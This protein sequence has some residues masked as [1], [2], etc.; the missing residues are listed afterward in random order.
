MYMHK[1]IIKTKWVSEV[2]ITPMHHDVSR[3]QP[4][5]KW[6]QL[7]QDR[8]SRIDFMTAEYVYPKA[9]LWHQLWHQLWEIQLFHK[10][11]LQTADVP[12]VNGEPSMA[13]LK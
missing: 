1:Y 13:S 10:D 7:R 2:Y 4:L 6:S 3:F 11:D 8:I 12:F 5:V 9:R